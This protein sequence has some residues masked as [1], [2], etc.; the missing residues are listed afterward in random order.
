MLGGV[1]VVV[2]E[3]SSEA[4][5]ALDVAT[6]TPDLLSGMNE[7]VSDAL[8]ISFFMI[9]FSELRERSAQGLF[10]EEN[11]LVQAF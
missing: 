7:V 11:H 6:G 9:M 5:A 10:P 2:A 4:V 1:A 3:H 8:M